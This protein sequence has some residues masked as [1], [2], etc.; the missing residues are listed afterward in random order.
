MPTASVMQDF[1]TNVQ[2][3]ELNLCNIAAYFNP[4]AKKWILLAGHWDT[5][6]RADYE[7]TSENRSKPIPGANDGASE[8]AV[9]MELARMFAKQKPD[10]GVYVVFFDGED[11]GTDDATMFLGARH[12]ADTLRTSAAVDGKPVKFEYGLLLDMIGD[13][14]LDIYE[15][16]NSVDAA[17]E[18]VDKVW[19]AAKNL[20][21]GDKFIPE[22]KYSISDDHIPLI[23][24][25]VKCIDIID[26][27]YAPWHTLEDTPD[28]CSPRSLE[29]VGEVVASVV[30]GEKP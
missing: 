13:K 4:N 1:T 21:Y 20:G 26:F 24:A 23:H 22:V 6:P 5:R 11:Y 9:L 19:K 10:V 30:Y 15:E 16:Q 18:V 28:K 2:G 29:T 7:V 25:G 8:T 12:F 14:N 3:K 27:D 17:P